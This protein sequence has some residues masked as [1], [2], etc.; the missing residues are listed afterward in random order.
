M[1]VMRRREGESILIGDVIEIQI[2]HAG[3]SRI[4]IGITAPK[5]VPVTAKEVKLVRQQ[6]VAAAQTRSAAALR[7]MLDQLGARPG[8]EK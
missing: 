5:C 4:K 1:L 8:G 3:P 7:A 6:N 2:L